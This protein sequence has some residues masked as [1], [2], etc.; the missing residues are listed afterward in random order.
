MQICMAP[1]KEFQIFETYNLPIRGKTGSSLSSSKS[2][3]KG[4]LIYFFVQEIANLGL[5]KWSLI[6]FSSCT[7]T[8]G[9]PI[10]HNDIIK[11]HNTISNFYPSKM[12]V[13][14]HP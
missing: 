14:S 11:Q 12:M 9:K 2:R 6:D 7:P 1:L 8:L 13:L 10:D 4:I 5:R 3:A